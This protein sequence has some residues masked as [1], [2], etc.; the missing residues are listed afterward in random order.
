MKFNHNQVRMPLY[1]KKRIYVCETEILKKDI[2]RNLQVTQKP[3]QI[4]IC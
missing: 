4:A 2:V 3:G 1:L